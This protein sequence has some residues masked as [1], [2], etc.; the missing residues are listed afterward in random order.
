MLYAP[1][2]PTNCQQQQQQ[3][4][5]QQSLCASGSNNH[6][7]NLR[8]TSNNNSNNNNTNALAFP[9][10]DAANR[11]S[12]SKYITVYPLRDNVKQSSQA[13]GNPN[14]ANCSA[15][16]SSA[17]I[18]QSSSLIINNN[19]NNINNNNT[20]S[21]L[22]SSMMYQSGRRNRL[23]RKSASEIRGRLRCRLERQGSLD[24]NA[25]SAIVS[26][27]IRQSSTSS[28]SANANVILNSPASNNNN[29]L[30]LDR[31]T[32]MNGNNTATSAHSITDK[33]QSQRLCRMS[34]AAAGTT[35]TESSNNAAREKTS[36]SD[37]SNNNL[38]S[39]SRLQRHRS[40]E[41]AEER[42]KSSHGYNK[43]IYLPLPK[44][45]QQHQQQSTQQHQLQSLYC[46]NYY[47]THRRGG[48]G[49]NP[50]MVST[51]GGSLDVDDLEM[52]MRCCSGGVG[53]SVSTQEK[54]G[55]RNDVITGGP[56]TLGKVLSIFTSIYFFILFP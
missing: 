24:A 19:N 39:N 47:R 26:R 50:R 6:L 23:D 22:S 36:C 48:S 51:S 13:N 46:R 55:E 34:T 20:P 18:N 32:S 37:I 30:L 10:G 8:V 16:S 53:T 43:G 33:Q 2:L 45:D 3:Q 49:G 54:I 38:K 41:T 42:L 11:T 4:H 5:D 17:G 35:E 56:W 7:R 21:Q 52:D 14:G 15:V 31:R 25:E 12:S 9:T 40:S 44:L 27:L 1:G 29:I 28:S